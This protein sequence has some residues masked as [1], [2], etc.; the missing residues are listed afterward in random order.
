MFVV[1]DDEL[2]DDLRLGSTVPPRLRHTSLAATVYAAAHLLAC[3]LKLGRLGG[4][5][6]DERALALVHRLA[7]GGVGLADGRHHDLVER[8][9]LVLSAR[10]TGGPVRL[11]EVAAAVNYSPYHMSRVFRAHTGMP[12]YAYLQQLRLRESLAQ[13]IDGRTR[14]WYILATPTTRREMTQWHAA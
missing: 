6:A 4:L 2:A 5:A 8:V 12:L 3:G 10:T 7:G 14:C 9:K 11:A 1:L 13:A